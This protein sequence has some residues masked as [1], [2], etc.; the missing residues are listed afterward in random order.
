MRTKGE[1]MPSL[2]DTPGDDP[3]GEFHGEPHG[4]LEDKLRA[5]PIFEGL[6]NRQLAELAAA[7]ELRALPGGAYL[8]RADE[9]A[10]CFTVLLEGEV[11]ITKPVG[12]EEVAFDHVAAPAHLGEI[13]LLTGTPHRVDAQAATPL[14]VLCV[15][16]AAFLAL[17]A[18][19]P[20]LCNAVMRTLARRIRNAE[21]L[22]QQREQLVTLGKLAAGLAHELNN[23]AAAVRRSTQ[24][25]QSR[26]AAQQ[27]AALRLLEQTMTPA[28]AAGLERLAERAAA[29][30]G[31]A[32][33]Q[34]LGALARSDREEE[35]AAWLAARGVEEG[36]RLAPTLAEAG[37]A[38]AHLAEIAADTPAATLAALLAWLE[39]ALAARRL[40]AA[41]DQG[42]ARMSEL[43]AAVKGFAFMDQAAVQEVDIHAGLENTLL[44]LAHELR[45]VTV[46]REF[47]DL[48]PVC[49]YGGELNQVWT[50]LIA[51]AADAL[52]GSGTIRLRTR[53][54]GDEVVVEVEDN[55]PGIPAKLQRKVFHPFVTT[56]AAGKGMGLG[57]DISKRIVEGRH[58]GRLSVVS[59]PGATRF[60]VRLPIEQS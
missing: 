34:Q 36:A 10:D 39:S 44:L 43:V 47:A 31:P 14:R 53:R 33:P 16:G 20:P 60:S 21:V 51:N 29:G 6:D 13:S 26:L 2:R 32:E 3:P 35:L 8:Y 46:E 28:Q 41:I 49:A 12:G 38:P 37:L 48:P 27:A 11:E 22:T 24:Q 59:Q 58:R 50:N 23:P 15:D 45:G 42:T 40:L 54:E 7:T 57:L 19:S 1:A 56:K 5:L 55:G 18:E 25:L 9:T 4:G 30:G 52:E 17:L